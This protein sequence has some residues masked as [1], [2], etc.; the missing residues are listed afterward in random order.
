MSLFNRLTT[1]T[2][3][4]LLKSADL[5]GEFNN[6]VNG[7]NNLDGAST[8]WTNVK[9]A[10][11]N[12]TGT[13]TIATLTATTFQKG[14]NTFPPILQVVQATSTTSFSMTSSSFS[15][16]NLTGSITPFFNTSK[17]LILACA[18]WFIQASNV[19]AYATLTRGSTNLAG[20][21]NFIAELF[22]KSI[23]TSLGSPLMMFYLDSPA[24]TSS[25]SYSVYCKNSDNASTL[26]LGDG[27]SLQVI[28]M[29]EVGT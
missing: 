14:G 24:T 2:A 20:A 18:T 26:V 8:S 10:T 5:N 25:T 9:T 16:T 15:A 13:G 6:L 29:I 3:L 17:V 1:W 19:S 12:T 4:Q 28:L 22:G 21:G 11:L 23:S 27:G 7:L